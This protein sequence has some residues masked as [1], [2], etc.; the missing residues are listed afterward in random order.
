MMALSGVRN[1]WLIF[2]R[3]CDFAWLAFTASLRASSSD[4]TAPFNAV[5]RSAME[6]VMVFKAEE[7]SPISSL[8]RMTGSGR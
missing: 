5:S 1:S 3:N 8:R 4:A 7:S 2:E 6:S